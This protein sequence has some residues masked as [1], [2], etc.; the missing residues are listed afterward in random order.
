[1]ALNILCFPLLLSFFLKYGEREITCL[2]SLS[3]DR[4]KR[5]ISPY[6]FSHAEV[7]PR[8]LLSLPSLR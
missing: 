2:Q 4:A 8:W 7:G 6:H 5:G 1:M 3:Q